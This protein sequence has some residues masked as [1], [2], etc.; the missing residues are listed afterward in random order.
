M[1]TLP[2]GT[3]SDDTLNLGLT[4]S[5]ADFKMALSPISGFW[6]D[7]NYADVLP[8]GIDNWTINIPSL[9]VII[10]GLDFFCTA[11]ILAPGK[12][13]VVVDDTTGLITPY[14]CLLVGQIS[15]PTSQQLLALVSQEGPRDTQGKTAE[16]VMNGFRANEPVLGEVLSGFIDQNI[17][18][19]TLLVW[20]HGYDIQTVDFDQLD[21]LYNPGLSFDLR[22]LGRGYQMNERNIG[23]STFAISPSSVV[24]YSMSP[25]EAYL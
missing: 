4:L 17:D 22:I 21:A 16:D 11:N 9:T 18:K 1:Q 12:N 2:L 15:S 23:F 13:I 3:V 7:E 6:Y 19:V 20:S 14:D 5:S 8:L 10:L 25:G 24:V